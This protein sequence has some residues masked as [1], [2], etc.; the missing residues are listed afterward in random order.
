MYFVFYTDF[1][2]FYEIEFPEK[3]SLVK[4]QTIF[5]ALDSSFLRGHLGK[6]QKKVFFLVVR[7]LNLFFSLYSVIRKC[8]PT[9]VNTE[10]LRK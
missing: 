6:P 10:F 2:Q 3:G 5:S 9:V 4:E 1:F 8:V 7:P